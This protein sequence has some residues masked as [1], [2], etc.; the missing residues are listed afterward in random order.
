[1]EPLLPGILSQETKTRYFL[2]PANM[3]FDQKCNIYSSQDFLGGSVA[4][5]P[6]ANAGDTGLT[7][8]LGRF[9]MPQSN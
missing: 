8:S 9:H 3:P 5:K 6:S 4:K 7:P 2:V 1:M